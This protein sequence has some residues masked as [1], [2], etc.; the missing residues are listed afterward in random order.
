MMVTNQMASQ[1]DKPLVQ[2]GGAFA[3]T[4]PSPALRGHMAMSRDTFSGHK[5][6]EECYWY[7][8]GRG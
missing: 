5:W 6:R 2:L 4:T 8:A 7:V 1:C 3:Q